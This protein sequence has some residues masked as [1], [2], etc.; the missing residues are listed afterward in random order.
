MPV[1]SFQIA[2]I[3]PIKCAQ[4]DNLPRVVILAGP[5]GVGKSTLLESLRDGLLKKDKER[6]SIQGSGKPLYIS[7]Y[8]APVSFPLHKSLPIIGPQER[9]IDVLQKESFSFPDVRSLVRSLPYYIISGTS[10]TRLA[11]DYAPY[12]E[13]KYRLAQIQQE[14]QSAVATVFTQRGE[15]PKGSFPKD[16]YGPFR[17]VIRRFLP[18]LEFRD[19]LVE[20]ETYKITFLN[21]AGDLIEFDAL[22]SGEM[23]IIAML[24]PFIEKEIENQLAKVKDQET[25]HEDLVVLI[26]SP[27]AYLHP[28]LQRNLL[29]YMR[30]LVEE[31]EKRGEALQFFVAT[32]SSTM[33]NEAEPEELYFLV[34]PDQAPEKNQLTKITT[35]EER[36]RLI[37]EVLGDVGFASLATGKPL[38]LLEGDDDREILRLMLPAIEEKFVLLPLGGRENVRRVAEALSVV[39][40]EL[41]SR[42]F[43]I[44]A[45]LDKDTGAPIVRSDFCVAWPRA[46]IENFLLLDSEAIYK[47]LQILVKDKKLKEKGIESEDDVTKLISEIIKDQSSIDQEIRKRIQEMLSFYIGNKWETIEELEKTAQETL[48]KKLRRVKEQWKRLRTDLGQIANDMEKALVEFDGKRILAKIASMFNIKREVL[49]RAIADRL[50]ASNTVPREMID[51]IS[52]IEQRLEI[53]EESANPTK[54]F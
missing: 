38:L 8:R 47:A 16:L 32:H 6:V 41:V 25:P 31:A 13:V 18:A 5:N 9:Y 1:N 40:S 23:D 20:G 14:F 52:T 15:I 44:F 17:E 27:E 50:G 4:A 35:D 48:K 3:G 30:D 34:F 39:M 37:R 46:C 36:L 10:R 24:F 51:L 19:I 11:P 33:I 12:F 7:P 45:I 21:R 26:D 54:S 49:A 53:T 28:T 22:S 43:K 42:G 29:E 2:G